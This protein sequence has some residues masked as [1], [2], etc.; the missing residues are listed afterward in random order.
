MPVTKSQSTAFVNVRGLGI[1]CFNPARQQ[2]EVALIRDGNHQLSL[3]V[4]KPGFIDGTG[5][6]TVGFVPVLSFGN[7]DLPDDVSIE[8]SGVGN[9]KI[10]GYEIFQ[11][12]DFARLN[13]AENDPHDFRWIVNL[14]G[15]E[16]HDASLSRTPESLAGEK[17]PVSRLYVGNGEFYAVTPDFESQKEMA[18][19]PYF[20]KKDAAGETEFGYLAET[21]G[22]NIEADAVCLKI[23]RGDAEETH[24]FERVEGCP[25][26]I[27]ISN[28]N[29]D[30]DAPAS[31][32]PV[33]YKFLSD[34]NGVS[35]ELNPAEETGDSGDAVQGKF[36]CHIARVNQETIDNFV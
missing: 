30:P 22:V 4:S 13:A 14:E 9:P 33:Y 7:G 3:K 28:M 34:E 21:M 20:S 23:R 1:V 11:S 31:D 29:P 26:K 15:D 16:L 6:D 12:G 5:K 10:A 27:E 25:F 8:I 19:T 2:S 17:P 32:L 36:Y 35:F 18:G 24:F